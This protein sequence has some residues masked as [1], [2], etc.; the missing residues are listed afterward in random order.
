MTGVGTNSANLSPA[1]GDPGQ[2]G[3]KAGESSW[4]SSST[5]PKPGKLR[6]NS[7]TSDPNQTRPKTVPIRPNRWNPE[8]VGR[9]CQCWPKPGPIRP[10]SPPT[11]RF[12]VQ[13]WT[14][15]V[16]SGHE[17][18]EHK[19]SLADSGHQISRWSIWGQNCSAT[20]RRGSPDAGRA[21]DRDWP[22]SGL[23]PISAEVGPDSAKPRRCRPQHGPDAGKTHGVPDSAEEGNRFGPCVT[24]RKRNGGRAS[25]RRPARALSASGPDATGS[26]R[27]K[28][29]TTTRGGPSKSG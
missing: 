23:A 6:E 8:S 14:Q 22:R 18:V 2:C 17:L 29:P 4:V 7:P 21:A 9:T 20:G 16:E 3:P 27:M 12:R 11:G 15:V 25:A 26:A 10:K 1:L 24:L 13:I 19:P 5:W 28:R